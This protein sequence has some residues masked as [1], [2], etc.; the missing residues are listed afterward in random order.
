VADPEAD[1]D[2]QAHE[3]A[4]GDADR[5]LLSRPARLGPQARSRDVARRS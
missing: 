4:E 5:R 3:G 2:T 1:P